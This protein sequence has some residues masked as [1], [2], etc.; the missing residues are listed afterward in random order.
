MAADS[1]EHPKQDAAARSQAGKERLGS[2][3]VFRGLTIAAGG[4]L[5]MAPLLPGISFRRRSPHFDIYSQRLLAYISI[6][7]DIFSVL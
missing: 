1:N 2:L 3:D 6:W 4:F 5:Q 7:I